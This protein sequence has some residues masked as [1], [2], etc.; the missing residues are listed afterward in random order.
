MILRGVGGGFQSLESMSLPGD[1]LLAYLQHKV[2]GQIAMPSPELTRLE[3]GIMETEL[4]QT[5]VC[6]LGSPT[7]QD[8]LMSAQ[9]KKTESLAGEV[10]PARS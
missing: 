2:V 8:C 10:A 9:T 7:S 6:A 4:P 3:L 5:S 1:G